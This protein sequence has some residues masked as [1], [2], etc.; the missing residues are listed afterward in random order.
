MH[1][2]T[3]NPDYSISDNHWVT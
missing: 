1:I 2:R 3:T